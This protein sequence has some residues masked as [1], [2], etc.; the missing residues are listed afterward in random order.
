MSDAKTTMIDPDTLEAWLA[1]GSAT[2]YDVREEHE[3]AAERIPGTRLLPL[4]RFDPA[5]AVA[6]PGSRLV[7]HCRSG[8]RCGQ[9]A[10]LMRAAGHDGTINRLA[11]GILGWKQAGKPTIAG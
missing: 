10:Q 11:G 1:E 6:A 8:V 2:V 3:W 9:A 5:A 7:F 4:S